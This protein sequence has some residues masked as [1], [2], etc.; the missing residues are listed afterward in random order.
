M[1]SFRH[2]S[3]DSRKGGPMFLQASRR[4]VRACAPHALLF[5]LFVL[6]ALAVHV[7]N[8]QVVRIKPKPSACDPALVDSAMEVS[9]LKDFG[10]LMSAEVG[11]IFAQMEQSLRAQ[12]KRLLPAER[13]PMF[14]ML[15]QSFAADA[16]D[17]EVERSV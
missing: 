12:G 9:S 15:Q 8:S 2:F 6:S 5:R 1:L 17:E 11:P 4:Y 3:S 10:N 7:A 14:E 13:G 16:V